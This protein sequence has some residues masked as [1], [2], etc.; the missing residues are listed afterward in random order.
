MD[1]AHDLPWPAKF[2]PA[3]GPSP[4]ERPLNPVRRFINSRLIEEDYDELVD[5]VAA[6]RWFESQGYGPLALGRRELAEYRRVRERLRDHLRGQRADETELQ[7]LLARRLKATPGVAC[8]GGQVKAG[9]YLVDVA[10]SWRPMQLILA[11]LW[12]G[13]ASGELSRLKVC[14]DDRCQISF[15]DRSRNRSREWCTSGECGNR[16]RVARHRARLRT[17]A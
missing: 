17:V 16:N 11:S 10:P 7:A 1:D 4:S 12:R 14:A 15:Y 8:A 6:R 2:V 9:L 5:E 3:L 13:A